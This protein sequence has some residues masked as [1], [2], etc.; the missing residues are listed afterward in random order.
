MKPSSFSKVPFEK[1]NHQI[2]EDFQT[3]IQFQFDYIARKVMIRT[4][5]NCYRSIGRRSKRECL[6]S[7]MS[8]LELN[9]LQTF[10]TYHLDSRIY[11]ILSLNVEVIDYQ[12][13]E[14]LDI[15]PKRKRDIILMSYYLEMSDAEIADELGVNRS[16]VYR[17]RTSALKIIKTLLE[18]ELCKKQKS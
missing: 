10:D 13:A 11:K 9:K 3:S 14:A 4:R 2:Q 18:E 12:I 7:E 8:E 17:N 15:L 1:L 16:T 5:S 6:F